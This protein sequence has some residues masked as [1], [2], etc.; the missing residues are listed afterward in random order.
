MVQLRTQGA[1]RAIG[2][3]LAKVADSVPEAMEKGVLEAGMITLAA[4]K[5]QIRKRF[6]PGTGNLSRSYN[7][8][9]TSKKGKKIGGE[10]SSDLA[11]AAI[12]NDGGIIRPRTRQNLAIPISGKAKR[13]WPREW[14][15]G[16]LF[17]IRSRRGSLLLVERIRDRI[18]PHYVLKPSVRLTGKRYLEHAAAVA[19]DAIVKTTGK[20]LAVGIRRATRGRS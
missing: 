11:Y 14:P 12:Q 9:W 18:V 13:I 10:V 3:F 4:V 7:F 8:N 2:A 20:A 5:D 6:R 19:S 15:K 1:Q 17:A 16:Q